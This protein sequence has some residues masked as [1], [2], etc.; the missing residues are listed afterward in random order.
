MGVAES[1][2]EVAGVEAAF[3]RDEMGQQGVAG[4]VE[5]HAEEDVGRALI[6]LA[7]KPPMA[8]V[9]LEQAVAGRQLHPL[10]VGHVP[11]RDDQAA[12]IGIAADLLENPVDLV[13]NAPVRPLPGAPLLAVDR[14]EIAVGVGPF[15]PDRHAM[16]LE[17]GDVGLAAAGTR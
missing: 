3:A 12:R 10:D 7:R 8:H 9:E 1:M 2:D 13:V 15:V 14:A 4:D 16:R 11:G 6:E 17:I 5:R